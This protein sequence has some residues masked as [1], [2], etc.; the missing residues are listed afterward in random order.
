MLCVCCRCQTYEGGFAGYPGQEAHGGYS[1]CGLA[2]LV[3]LN[4]PEMCNL[5]RLLVSMYTHACTRTCTCVQAC[6]HVCVYKHTHT[7]THTHTYTYTCTHTHTLYSVSR[8]CI[9]LCYLFVYMCIHAQ[10]RVCIYMISTMT[11]CF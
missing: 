8:V 6:M 9:C 7:H 1:F 10:V 2:A 4:Q 3:I 5:P 11:H